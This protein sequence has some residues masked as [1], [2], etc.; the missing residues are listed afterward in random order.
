MTAPKPPVFVNKDIIDSIENVYRSNPT[1]SSAI[2][3][4]R[5]LLTRE[6]FVVNGVTDSKTYTFK[7]IAGFP[8][9]RIDYDLIPVLNDIVLHYILYGM[10][11][12]RVGVSQ[13]IPD[14]ATIVVVPMRDVTIKITWNQFFQRKYQ[15]YSTGNSNTDEIPT[16]YVSVVDHPDEVGRPQSAI[17]LCLQR[18]VFGDA[19]WRY[20]VES[21]YK[22]INPQYIFTQEEVGSKAASSSG[23]EAAGSS[24]H[25][26][27]DDGSG[28]SGTE[29][30]YDNA[31]A[32]RQNFFNTNTQ[33]VLSQIEEAKRANRERPITQ[34]DVYGGFEQISQLRR[35]IGASAVEIRRIESKPIVG[36][37]ILSLPV[38]M[39]PAPAPEIFPPT[40]FIEI[41]ETIRSDIFRAL[42]FLPPGTS[43]NAEFASNIAYINENLSTVLRMFARKTEPQLSMCA[44]K[45]LDQEL[46]DIVF[47]DL[48]VEQ[49]DDDISRLRADYNTKEA[50]QY[51]RDPK[52]EHGYTDTAIP[53]DDLEI[54]SKIPVKAPKMRVRI[55]YG[56]NPIIDP[57]TAL[58]LRD[59]H[60]ITHKAYQS[61]M[62]QTMD[63]PESMREP[64][65][66][67]SFVKLEAEILA[68]AK[69]KFKPPPASAAAKP[70]AK[71]P[72]K[73]Q[74]TK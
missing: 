55:Q 24:I 18:L 15:A 28:F 26:L 73:K 3:S 17:A 63:L 35:D 67:E 46:F 11:V 74:R 1:V 13:N 68:E 22:R 33:T 31:V 49:F 12:I 66:L 9:E 39:R 7:K 52:P 42:G 57:E 56:H 70:K 65:P 53:V 64:E 61:I 54:L 2:N 25:L 27:T 38:G 10:V 36:K 44:S 37:P 30:V 20:Y 16:S 6:E 51:S 23:M 34:E 5:N 43:G 29:V 14:A 19:L 60:V 69:E 45:M 58:N 4:F 21:T 62:L 47:N 50:L 48:V 32:R 40:E 71:K 41:Q 59:T 8:E 72:A